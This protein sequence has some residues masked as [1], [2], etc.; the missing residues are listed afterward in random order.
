VNDDLIVYQGDLS[1]A[2]MTMLC[3]LRPRDRDEPEID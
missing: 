1:D 3:A 2:F